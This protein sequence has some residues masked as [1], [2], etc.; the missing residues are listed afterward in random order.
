[1]AIIVVHRLLGSLY[2]LSTYLGRNVFLGKV[3][4]LK[5]SRNMYHDC[6]IIFTGLLLKVSQPSLSD[7]L[8]YTHSQFYSGKKTVKNN[9][10]LVFGRERKK[11]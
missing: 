8:V 1:L 10:F 6:Q 3:V 4:I 5:N 11:S 7:L 9:V 2:I